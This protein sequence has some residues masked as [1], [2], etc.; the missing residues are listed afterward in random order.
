MLSKQPEWIIQACH[1]NYLFVLI[2]SLLLWI[3]SQMTFSKCE[4]KSV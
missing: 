3:D 1:K 4:K 2:V